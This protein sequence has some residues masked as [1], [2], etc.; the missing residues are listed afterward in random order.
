VSCISLTII[1]LCK[2]LKVHFMHLLK[3]SIFI[4]IAHLMVAVQAQL[5]EQKITREEYIEM[6][7]EAAIEEMNA[8]GIPASIKLA[9]A[10]LESGSGNSNLALN[11]YNHFGIKCHKG[12]IG[13]SYHM[14]DDE[15]N[16]CFRKYNNSLES[17]K[18]HS[19]FL[20][21]RDRYATLFQLD[22]KDYKAWAHGLKN[23]GYA[24]NPRYPELLIGII[25]NNRL[26]EY[27]KYYQQSY[28]EI[29]RK[30]LEEAAGMRKTTGK[31]EDFLPVSI[32]P[33][34]RQIFENN[35]VKFIYASQGD[36]FHQIAKDFN[37][38]SHQVFRN[39]DLKRKDNITEGQVIY[40]E[41]KKNT[42]KAGGHIVAAGESLQSISQVY[43]IKLKKLARLNSLSTNAQLFPGQSI[44]LK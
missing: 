16:E 15:K 34:G 8:F 27:D 6:Y 9:Q 19:I 38:Y 32:G 13:L 10:I 5:P 2:A 31:N 26:Y 12:W 40:L 24:T 29:K 35:G 30:E 36:S 37:I 44:K 43:A 21:T 11:A 18:D 39:N 25:E 4:F 1:E 3:T 23:A 22:V 28:A 7:K 41:R 20:T 17:F 33:S 42:N 14:D